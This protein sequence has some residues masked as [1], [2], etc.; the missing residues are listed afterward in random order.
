[1]TQY[2]RIIFD[3]TLTYTEITYYP[4]LYQDPLNNPKNNVKSIKFMDLLRISLNIGN[5]EEL[6]ESVDIAR[7]DNYDEIILLHKIFKTLHKSQEGYYNKKKVVISEKDVNMLLDKSP[8]EIIKSTNYGDLIVRSKQIP[9][10]P[11][12]NINKLGPLYEPTIYDDPLNWEKYNANLINRNLFKK[13]G[14][15]CPNILPYKNTI[16]TLK[17]LQSK[18]LPKIEHGIDP[19][20]ASYFAEFMNQHRL[21]SFDEISYENIIIVYIYVSCTIVRLTQIVNKFL[22]DVNTPKY[23]LYENYLFN[24]LNKGT[25]VDIYNFIY[26]KKFKEVH[27]KLSQFLNHNKINLNYDIEELNCEIITPKYIRNHPQVIKILEEKK[28]LT[29]KI[30]LI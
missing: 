6:N 4:E 19:K 15:I 3:H 2:G 16:D 12:P 5:K 29:Q 11:L 17:I 10:K 8:N 7:I 24:L 28:K 14:E 18:E 20:F 21:L 9:F 23:L 26:L 22:I 25:I 13:A 30:Q 1:M 27:N